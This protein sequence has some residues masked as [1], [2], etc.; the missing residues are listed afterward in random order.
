MSTRISSLDEGYQTGDLSLYPE[1]LD[2]RDILY[3]ATNNAKVKLKQTLTYNSKV[4]IVDGDTS[5]FPDTGQIRLG[6]EGGDTFELIAYDKKTFNTF[7]ELQRGFGGSL[8]NIWRP[9]NTYVTNS[10]VADHHNGV[11]D[12]II[13]IEKNLGVTD[14]PDEA[15]LNGILKFQE[16]RFLSPKVK[17]QAFPTL[18]KPSLSVRFQN[19][20]TGHIIRYFWDF[21]DGGTS[22]EK[23]PIHTYN[24][25]GT[26]TVKLN[27]ITSTGGQGVQTK[28]DYITVDRDTTVPFF[29]VDN[30]SQPY[31]IKT[32]AELTLQ[33]TATEPKTFTFVDQTDG[34]IVQRNWLFGDSDQY[35]QDDP[36]L[37]TVS[38]IFAEPGEYIVTL[39]VVLSNRRLQKVELPESLVVF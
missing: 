8:Q 3:T 35:V 1:V 15:S 28:T 33:G 22:L 38:H 14:N 16:V 39:L 29:Y 10:V 4:V 27:T 13:N 32:A 34:D 5:A 6:E 12:A 25:E 23:S 36:D 20:T 7:Q 24:A 30:M 21:G 2:D 9:G 26:Y 37:H 18:G 11:K 19:Y 17:F 31:S